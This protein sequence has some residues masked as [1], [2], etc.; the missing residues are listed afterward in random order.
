MLCTQG[1]HSDQSVRARHAP[2]VF[3]IDL[4]YLPIANRE[5]S[6]QEIEAALKRVEDQVK[7]LQPRYT[8]T[9]LFHSAREF[10]LARLATFVGML[11]IGKAECCSMRLP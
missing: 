6:L 10:L 2:T 4:T 9:D 7:K 5:Y 1:R 3:D 11:A 8:I